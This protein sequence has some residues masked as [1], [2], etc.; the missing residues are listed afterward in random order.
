M[1]YRNFML[2]IDF[3][4]SIP[5]SSK[6]HSYNI[7]DTSN[8][9]YAICLH[10]QS[11]CCGVPDEKPLQIWINEFKKRK[12]IKKVNALKVGPMGREGEYNLY[13]NKGEMNNCV[14]RKFQEG[15]KKLVSTLKEPGIVV[16]ESNPPIDHSKSEIIDVTY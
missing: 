5:F 6:A 11:I 1:K 15:L 12:H 4:L 14:F 13:F 7:I 3:Y 10:F 2:S 16:Y 8:K 9:V